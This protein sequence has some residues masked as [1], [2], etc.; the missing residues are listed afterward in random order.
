MNEITSP[1]P[2]LSSSLISVENI[3]LPNAR[4]YA[5]LGI[6]SGLP[7]L[8]LATLAAW[9]SWPDMFIY[10]LALLG[11]GALIGGIVAASRQEDQRLN[12][13][14]ASIATLP[15]D[16]L[17]HA[18]FDLSLS[19]KTRVLIANHLN[20]IDPG[21]HTRLESQNEDWQSLKAAGSNMAA[22]FRSCSGGSCK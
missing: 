9:Q 8:A 7:A 15:S 13:A 21:W 16:I 19:E 3:V 17:A 12:L 18:T 4:P 5:A 14:K 2:T 22:C 1:T 6:G 10:L 11:I 20:S